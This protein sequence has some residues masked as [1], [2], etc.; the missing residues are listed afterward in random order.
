MRIL[1]IGLFMVTLGY[2]QVTRLLVFSKTAGFRHSTIDEGIAM[3]S[4]LGQRYGFEVDASEDESVMTAGIL[5]NYA[6]VIF[7]HTTG[8]F[9]NAQSQE[10]LEGYIQNGGGWLGIHAAADAENQWGWYGGL[11]G[12]NAYFESHPARQTA[13]IVVEDGDHPSTQHLGETWERFDE[14]YNFDLNPRPSVNVL[15]T[16]DEA[17][18]SGGNMGG[19]HPIAWWHDYDGGR[20]FVRTFWAES[21]IRQES[22]LAVR[23]AMGLPLSR[24][25]CLMRRER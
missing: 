15:L 6:A 14:W 18:Y 1:M 21:F 11:L 23:Y 9:L 5:E 12:G 25:S 2:G 24:R 19:D 3:I 22:S 7:L 13:T 4:E 8:N 17:S 16:L 20:S 10:A